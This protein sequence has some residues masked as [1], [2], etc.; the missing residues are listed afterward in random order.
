MGS[1]NLSATGMASNRLELDGIW[2]LK[3]VPAV[4]DAMKP[5]FKGA[6]E[7]LV[8]GDVHLD[9]KRAGIIPDPMFGDNVKL[10]TWIGEQKWIYERDFEWNGRRGS[11]VELVCDGLCLMA[12]VRLNGRLIGTHKNM[13]RPFI[14]EVSGFLKGKNRIEIRLNPFDPASALVPEIG[15]GDSFNQNIPPI[16]CRKRGAMRKAAYTF[17]WDWTQALPVCGIWQSVRLE[18]VPEIK[19][20]DFQVIAMASGE[21]E[22]GLTCER[23][24]QDIT[25]SGEFEFEV[26]EVG[27]G[28]LVADKTFKDMVGPGLC[29]HRFKMNIEKP[30]LWWPA[31]YGEQ[32]L[33]RI[34][35]SVRYNGLD[36]VIDRT[37]CVFGFRDVRI[38]EENIAPGRDSFTFEINGRKVFASGTNWVPPSTIPG[39]TKDSDYEHLIDL[40]IKSGMNYLRLWGGGVYPSKSF[41]DLCDRHGIMIWNDFMF[42]NCE[43]PDF[44]PAFIAEVELEV[45]WATKALRNHPSIVI[46]CGSNETDGV[47]GRRAAIRPGGRYYGYKTLHEVIPAIVSRLD[48]SREYRPSSPCFGR[49]QPDCKSL[50]EKKHG[51]DHGI[52]ANPFSNDARVAAELPAFLNEWYCGAPTEPESTARYLDPASRSWSDEVFSLHNFL[53]VALPNPS[54]AKLMQEVF[55]LSEMNYL[56][57]MPFNEACL[58]FSDFDVEYIRASIEQYRRNMRAFSG[59]AYWMINSAYPSFDWSLIDYYGLPKAAW[60]CFKRASAPVL[61][62]AGFN[63]GV[64]EAWIVNCSD[65]NLAGEL[66]LTLQAF[67][68]RIIHTESRT[69]KSPPDSSVKF[70]EIKLDRPGWNPHEAFVKIEFAPAKSGHKFRNHRVLAPEK[71][72]KRPAAHV[73]LESV[74][75]EPGVFRLKTDNFASH[76]SL[77]PVTKENI[78]DDN[79]FDMLPGEEKIVRFPC[80]RPAKKLSVSW[81]NAPGRPLRLYSISPEK[82]ELSPGAPP[83]SI[84]VVLFNSGD[85]VEKAAVKLSLPDGVESQG[86]VKVEVQPRSVSTVKFKLDINPYLVK[87]GRQMFKVETTGSSAFRTAKIGDSFAIDSASRRIS[88][89]NCSS[90]L[91]EAKE[92][93]FE[94]SNLQGVKEKTAISVPPLSPGK[95]ISLAIPSPSTA[96]IPCSGAIFTGGNRPV[97]VWIAPDD[98]DAWWESLPKRDFDSARLSVGKYQVEA[99]PS[100]PKF[101]WRLHGASKDTNLTLEGDLGKTEILFALRHD[102]KN[103]YFDYLM[104]GMNFSQM[105]SGS[106]NVWLGTCAELALAI[107]P[108]ER[109]FEC[110]MALTPDGHELFR[111]A[112]K[113]RET[114][115][116]DANDNLRLMLS[117][118]RTILA[119]S[120]VID[121]HD[122]MGVIPDDKILLSISFRTEPGKLCDVFGGIRMGKNP[123]KYG[124]LKM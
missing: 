42:G 8:P 62:C 111:R 64:A 109:L 60:Y 88:L 22:L 48:T 120:A 104:R 51:V 16:Y 92:L 121:M 118:D 124:K 112:S 98:A 66:S 80:G 23:S 84:S 27:S 77:S 110:S 13:H 101:W 122:A 52:I 54:G 123:A 36:G 43:M 40:A 96:S 14:A 81:K 105:Q 72:L 29:E 73:S 21:M 83:P 44:D 115:V 75:G 67:D 30:E 71:E 1:N 117:P 59:H 97:P 70:F 100:L 10:C 106:G 53:P 4:K 34:E 35:V 45:T 33:Y 5:K 114:M 74:K 9:L 82:L 47:C 107:S 94:W 12:E 56:D 89:K 103:L 55:T 32:P 18:S 63:E 68:G 20:R 24:Q 49:H 6:I 76:V 25:V 41:Y 15:W 26:F 78:P 19:L 38:V 113:G 11:K 87:P 58:L 91:L 90:T 93:S 108:Q 28:R 119:C 61:P 102:R 69:V 46:W 3:C 79:C 2:K 17:G 65:K 116:L 95:A 31:N 7:A 37:D 57:K 99:W 86:S 39:E 50:R 85:K